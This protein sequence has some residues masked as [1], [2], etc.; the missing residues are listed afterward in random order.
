MI[1]EQPD[2][3]LNNTG[4]NIEE[5]RI[6]IFNIMDVCLGI[7]MD[8]I[9]GIF[10]PDKI[11]HRNYDFFRF[12]EKVLFRQK[13]IKYESPMMLLLKNEPFPTGVII[14]RPEDINVPVPVNLIHPLPYL[15][16]KNKADS[17][18]WSVAVIDK[19]IVLLVDADRLI[20]G[21]TVT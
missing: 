1:P 20:A 15:I 12:H 2:I 3:D 11:K 14:D 19:K 17:P 5:I 4:Q 18:V 21:K 10:K 13:N 16:E 8:W 7:D 9:S 6:L